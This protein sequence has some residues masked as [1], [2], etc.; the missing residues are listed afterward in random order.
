MTRTASQLDSDLNRLGRHHGCTQRAGFLSES[1][2]TACEAEPIQVHALIRHHHAGPTHD[3]PVTRMLKE[4]L[5][6]EMPHRTVIAKPCGGRPPSDRCPARLTR[7]GEARF[8]HRFGVPAEISNPI[9]RVGMAREPP[10][11][12]RSPP[13]ES[14]RVL[15]PGPGCTGPTPPSGPTDSDHDGSLTPGATRMLKLAG[16]GPGCSRRLLD[17]VGYRTDSDAGLAAVLSPPR[18]G[19][20]G[21]FEV[22]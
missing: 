19:T 22:P 20:G 2:G 13:S 7:R 6:R 21:K 15:G 3:P 9:R 18:H 16:P 8:P 12:A 5:R 11:R 10:D 1:R 14:P 17:Y 4:G